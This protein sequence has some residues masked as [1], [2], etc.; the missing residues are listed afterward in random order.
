MGKLQTIKPTNTKIVFFL[1]YSKNHRQGYYFPD[2]TFTDNPILNPVNN[3][4]ITDP[5]KLVYKI[6]KSNIKNS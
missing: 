4:T 5:S 3:E 6:N 2:I 1:F